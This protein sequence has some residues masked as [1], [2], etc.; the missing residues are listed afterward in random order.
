VLTQEV[1]LKTLHRVFFLLYRL[2]WLKGKPSFSYHYFVRE[3][4]KKEDIV[5]DL[6]ANLGYFARTFSDLTPRG[7]VIAIEPIPIFYSVLRHFL[8]SRSN[9]K[10]HNVALGKESGSVLMVLPETDGLIR[11]GL[12]HVAS[13]EAELDLHQHQEVAI[14][15][16]KGFFE[17]IGYFSYLKCDIEG[18]EGVVIPEILG[19]LDRVRPLIQIEIADTNKEELLPLFQGIGYERYSVVRG[20]LFHETGALHQE[21]DYLFIPKEKLD[22]YK[23]LL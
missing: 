20:K 10:L 23:H 18:Y 15:S 7:K 14:R 2:R 5:V 12:P 22:N 9:V 3:L 21:G 1:Y 8:G 19:V 4:V 6:G 17:E 16:A 13:D 11:T